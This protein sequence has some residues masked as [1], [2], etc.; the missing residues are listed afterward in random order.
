MRNSAHFVASMLLCMGASTQPAPTVDEQL[1]QVQ[2][3]QKIL[4][5][6]IEQLAQIQMNSRQIIINTQRL[7]NLEDV[8]AHHLT[9]QTN[10]PVAIAVLQEQVAG[11]G[12][13]LS[14]ILGLVAACASGIAIT[15]VRKMIL[16]PAQA[17][18]RSEIRRYLEEIHA[19]ANEGRDRADAAYQAANTVNEKI[20][21]LSLAIRDENREDRHV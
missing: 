13:A 20:A 6:Q 14:W 18:D 3:Q 8:I 10:E 2:A 21:G 1:R 11:A 17:K 4:R 19:T 16:A 7:T 9:A 15:F 12:R 5:E